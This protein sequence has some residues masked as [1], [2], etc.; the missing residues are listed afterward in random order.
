MEQ[1]NSAG[2]FS[3][4]TSAFGA[5][6]VG[7]HSVGQNPHA[8]MLFGGGGGGGGMPGVYG[9]FGGG[10]GS[11]GSQAS[12]AGG[13]GFNAFG[14]FN[15]FSGG[16]LGS[17]MWSTGASRTATPTMGS[18]DYGG[19]GVGA[20]PAAAAAAAVGAA[21]AL[22]GLDINSGEYMAM[23]RGNPY[24]GAGNPYGP[25]PPLPSMPRPP[26]PPP[27]R[28]CLTLPATSWKRTSNPRLLS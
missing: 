27:G 14:S 26:M 12:P 19:L 17:G 7:Q 23:G 24:G 25:Q 22:R 9:Q 20:D 28:A 18:G 15:A 8:A 10:G 11:M 6:S 3:A 13:G 2:V 4:Y 5:G 16:G 1:Q 21:A